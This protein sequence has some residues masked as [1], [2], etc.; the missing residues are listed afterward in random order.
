MAS[1]TNGKKFL[2]KGLVFTIPSNLQ[3]TNKT[4]IKDM[5]AGTVIPALKL[6]SNTLTKPF[7]EDAIP[8]WDDATSYV[9]IDNWDKVL[10]LSHILSL[11]QPV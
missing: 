4:G 9:K 8:V 3:P 2:K 10:D 1:L 7:Y 6:L 11:I 5:V